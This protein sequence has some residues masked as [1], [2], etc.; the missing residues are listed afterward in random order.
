MGLWE[1]PGPLYSLLFC[2]FF[3]R[4][5]STLNVGPHSLSSIFF[6]WFY[7]YSRTLSILSLPLSSSPGRF[8]SP[9]TDRSLDLVCET[10]VPL[11]AHVS[12]TPRYTDRPVLGPFSGRTGPALLGPSLVINHSS[13]PHS[14]SPVKYSP[15]GSVVFL[16]P[17]MGSIL[18]RV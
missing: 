12:G 16:E 6:Y 15:E 1:R 18:I 7:I 5:K 8:R 9:P 10:S 17:K 13:W 4:Y 3:F 11:V 2:L 14:P